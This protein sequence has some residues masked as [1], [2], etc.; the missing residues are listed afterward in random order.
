MVS[1]ETWLPPL[2]RDQ[3][4]KMRGVIRFLQSKENFPTKFLDEI[5]SDCDKEFI[6]KR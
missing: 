5:V 4:Q 1:E 2:K 3:S 6:K